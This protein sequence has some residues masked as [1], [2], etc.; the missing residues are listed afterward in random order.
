MSNINDSYKT[1]NDRHGNFSAISISIASPEDIMS[2]SHG[3]IKNSDTI[4]YRTF[5]PEKDGLF[6]ARI[7]GP[8][9][10]Y[11]CLCGKYKRIKF[12]GVVCEKC[13]VEVTL[14]KVRRERMGH[15]DLVMP[16]VHSW[17]LKSSPSR[18]ATLLG[19]QLKML[20]KVVYFDSYIVINNGNTTLEKYSII[21]ES[22]YEDALNTFGDGSFV[23]GTGS[24]AIRKILEN[25]DLN[26]EKELILSEI[27][28]T[29]SISKLKNLNKRF[30][31]IQ[32]FL[33]SGNKPEWMVLTKLPVIPPDLRPLV[34]L[35]GAKFA[36]SGLNDLYKS[37]INRNNR[38]IRL[39]E[40][41]APDIIVRNE[42]RM[43]QQAVNALLDNSS[44]SKVVKNSMNI[45]LKSLSDN[46]KGKNGRFR[47]NLLGKRVDYSGRSVIVVG[48]D[49]RLHE[50]GIPKKMALELFKPFVYGRLQLYG[51]A[52]SIQIARKMVEKELPDVWEVL[53][54]IVKE[55][56]ILLNR[57]PTLHRLGI[58]AFEPRLVE[59]K[60][61]HL[62]PLV[63]KAFNADFDGDQMAVHIPL[64][65]EAQLEAR[66]LMLSSN[67]IL[68]PADGSPTIIPTKDIVLG[69]YYATLP[70]ENEVGD[71][72]IFSDVDHLHH[73]INEG[74]VS[75]NT[76]IK[77]LLNNDGKSKLID[78]CVGRV[79]LHSLLPQGEKITLEDVNLTI[80]AKIIGSIIDMVNSSYGMKETVMFADKVMQFG[81]KSATRSGLSFGK[82]DVQIP[83]TKSDH[84]NKTMQIVADA[85]AQYRDGLIT[86]KEKYNRV[87]DEWDRCT[88][89][90]SKDMMH[91]M[92]LNSNNSKANSLFMMMNSGARGSESQCKQM[93]GMRG[94]M[95]KPSGEI[96]E[97]PIISNFKEGLSTIE[98]FESS[99][100][101]RK[102]MADTALRTADAGYLTRRLVDVAQDYVITEHDCNA[103]EG[104]IFTVKVI[105]GRVVEKLSD[106]IMGRVLAKDLLDINGNTLFKRNHL[107]SK[108]DATKID[109]AISACVRSVTKCEAKTGLCS[110]CYGLDQS[111]STI[112]SIGD[113]VGII[114]AQSIGEPG[115]Q[116]TMRTFQTGG[117][118]GKLSNRMSIV[119][120]YNGKIKF[121]RISSITDKSGNVI[122]TSNS[123]LIQILNDK[124]IILSEY[125]IPYGSRLVIADGD[126]I[127]VGSKIAMNDSY[128]VPIVSEYDGF[129]KFFD[130]VNGISCRERSDEFGNSYK[131]IQDWLK[132]SKYL[133]PR[134]MICDDKGNQ[135][136][137][138]NGEDVIYILPIGAI[139]SISDGAK[140]SAGDP[141][142][143]IPKDT[144]VSKDITGGLPIV[145]SIF[146][147]RIPK[148]PAVISAH[149]GVVSFDRN[150]RIKNVIVIESE[151]GS[152][153]E[154]I[155]KK[156]KYIKVKDGEFVKKG[157]III[158]GD[159]DPHSLLDLGGVDALVMH[160]LQ[161]VQQ[162]Y[163]LQGV[164]I[165][166]KHIEIII[167][168]MLKFVEVTDPGD[169][170]LE[171]ESRITFNSIK[172]I[173]NNLISQGKNPAKFKRYLYGITKTSIQNDS[174]ISAAAFQETVK[175]LTEAAVTSK[176]DDLIGLKENV[177]VGRLIPVGT[178]LA[179]SNMVKSD[180]DLES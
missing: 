11:E 76:K 39:M 139:I 120:D 135:I 155:V 42:K 105:E 143:R 98:Y 175:V 159:I 83:D 40:M 173:N 162:V 115:T 4:N 144:N 54:G 67:N 128:S 93:A 151:D 53:D 180:I 68:N 20:E 92:S 140:I 8:V 154:Y 70:M 129:V 30:K 171:I 59:T 2:W 74:K 72:S 69:L 1:N 36:S 96:I 14:S 84:V 142:A 73:A 107:I 52:P 5:K 178:G 132:I 29:K 25:I 158:D 61:I 66:V 89:A 13:G 110:M 63:C 99:H 130:L 168:S 127:S 160:I 119:S 108:S 9:R 116:L 71:G 15:I 22:Q 47:E 165:D 57:A 134:V 50:C 122:V 153:N 79:I 94:L 106:M 26:Y 121:S 41:G 6:C 111:K 172:D 147:A 46:L 49:L 55:H 44:S 38:L 148:N 97:N 102:G 145:E 23:V 85:Q 16:V 60:A 104:I 32:S 166:N 87:T 86:Y 131:L 169:S 80:N 35:D 51:K 88:N 141:I 137:N 18:I 19:V 157:D 64:S 133:Q 167:L 45:P 43:L 112:A 91:G 124:D 27:K 37:V 75:Y 118:A 21:D 164:K 31:L 113:A 149:D 152:K 103:Q 77:Y 150:A 24:E 136:K 161:G 146:E 125:K 170:D 117:I 126:S 176:R 179:F 114:A 65:V 109:M 100:G 12:K 62:H 33:E 95:V 90:I 101:A 10:D 82:D 58:Q 3:S 177:I 48:P 81:F 78:T 28:N 34:M 138:S 156:G 123:G 174:F 17:F 56:L 7:F 163:K